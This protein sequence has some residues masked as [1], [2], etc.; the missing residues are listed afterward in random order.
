MTFVLSGDSISSSDREHSEKNNE[1]L[2]LAELCDE[3]TQRTRA[4]EKPSVEEY[5]AAYPELAEQIACVFP[6]LMMFGEL[7]Q[8]ISESDLQTPDPHEIAGYEI[9]R[10]LGSGGMGVVYEA[11]HPTVSRR[12]AIKVLNTHRKDPERIANRFLR[13]AETA[14]RLNHP[15]IVPFLDCGQDGDIAYLSMHYV[16][17]CSLDHLL[18]RFWQNETDDETANESDLPA[19]FATFIGNDFQRIATLGA[20]V[21]SAMSQAHSQGTIHR[22][23]KPANLILDLAGK[24]WVTDFGLAKLRDEESDLSRTGDLIGTPRYM[25][26]EQIRGLADERSDVYAL[27][28]TLYELAG[29]CRAWGATK[30]SELLGVRSAFALTEITEVNS[31]V[32]ND[33]A[34]I[35]MKACAHDPDHRFQSAADLQHVLN[36]CA[37]GKSV[38]D[39]RIRSDA[40]HRLSL[41]RPQ[42]LLAGFIGVFLAGMLFQNVPNDSTAI[43]SEVSAVAALTG[44]TPAL[45]TQRFEVIEGHSM[46]RTV[47]PAMESHTGLVMWWVSGGADAE[48]FEIDRGRGLLQPR[49][50]LEFDRPRDTDGDNVYHVEVGMRSTSLDEKVAVVFTVVPHSESR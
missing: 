3:F 5:T 48:L 46:S 9:V 29:G 36:R 42:F 21:A 40:G 22:D 16:D 44:M 38:S 35:I 7:D 50:T 49:E 32:P 10:R 27:G 19:D 45:A 15:N 14:S 6:A 11:T 24:I 30:H 47:T 8:S 33:L 2:L 31:S 13:E 1:S 23:I 4:G 39:R 37:H 41:V 43:T 25:A 34:N 17:G 26:P 28:V 18:E 20:D 12:M